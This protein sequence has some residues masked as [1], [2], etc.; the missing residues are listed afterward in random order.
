MAGL[1]PWIKPQFFDDNGDALAGGFLYSYVAGT[2]TPAATYIDE[3]E[4][5]PN[6]NPIVLDSGGRADI[7]LAEGTSYKFVLTDL[8]DVPIWTLD[9]VEAIDVTQDTAWTEH[10]ITDGQS[11]TILDGEEIDISLYSSGKYE[12][13]IIRGTTVLAGG[14]LEVQVVNGVPRVYLGVFITDPD[15]AHGITFSV[16]QVGVT[17]VYEL[18]AAASV[19]PGNGT[20]KLSRRLVPA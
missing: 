17:T 13:E 9:N 14:P 5:T 16:T 4:V 1:L 7:F 19:G 6:T 3:S 11:A 20:I 12:C 15:I 18:N 2:S 10:A 8:N